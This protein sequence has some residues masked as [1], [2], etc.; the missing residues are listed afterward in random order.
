LPER[1]SQQ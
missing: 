1:K